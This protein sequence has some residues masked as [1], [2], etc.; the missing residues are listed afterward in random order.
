[1]TEDTYRDKLNSL[2]V[3]IEEL[4]AKLKESQT[5]DTISRQA[6]I[7]AFNVCVT[8]GRGNGKS[9]AFKIAN[10]YADI[11]RKRIEALPSAQPEIIRCED[12]K[13]YEADIMGNPW[14]VCCH[15]D[16]VIDNCGSLVDEKGWCYR[17]ERR[18]DG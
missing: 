13:H 4:R 16:W 14:G 5:G 6:A 7:D 11:V 12:C 1:M 2:Q 15:K 3:E 8:I 18:S 17:A 10:D 9:V